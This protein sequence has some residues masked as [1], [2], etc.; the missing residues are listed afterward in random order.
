MDSKVAF[1]TGITGQ[2]GGILA[3]LLLQKN[4]KVYGL[5]RRSSSFNTG[6]IEHI[7]N[8][9]N[10]KLIYGDISD[11]A[12]ISSVIRDIQPDEIYNLAAQSHVKVSFDVPI[13]SVNMNIL[14]TINV[15]EAIRQY[16]PHSKYYQASSSEMYGKVIE[17]PQTENTPFHPRSPY[18]CSKVYSYWQTV[19]YREAYNIFAS[20]GI[21]FNH[22]GEKRGETFVT[23]KIT[24]AVTRIKLGLQNELILGN[25]DSKRD[26]G[27]YKDYCEAMYLILQHDKP[28]DFVIASGETHSVRE[29]L[30]IAFSYL[31]LDYEKY[32][33]IDQKYFRPSE[34]DL[35]LGDP[36]K[37][38]RELNWTP[39]TSFKE[40][41]RIMVDSDMEIAKDEKYI[42]ER[43]Q[44]DSKK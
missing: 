24:R 32:V 12:N 10:L 9:P 35:L 40:L 41:V 25:I 39:K 28:D 17:T 43:R 33:K 15:L 5:I 34:V 16:S 44:N 26:W 42:K 1:I 6:R 8:H 38:K 11:S 2:D 7:Y 31:D 14:G 18:A 30:E 13:N 27:Y 29:F 37:A 19:N 36:S 21:L 3:E 23:R 4:Y 22:S 20:N